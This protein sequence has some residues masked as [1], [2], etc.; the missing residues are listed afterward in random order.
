MPGRALCWCFALLQFFIKYIYTHECA[1]PLRLHT[2]KLLGENFVSVYCFQEIIREGDAGY[3]TYFARLGIVTAVRQVYHG[4]GF[5]LVLNDLMSAI[6]YYHMGSIHHLFDGDDGTILVVYLLGVVLLGLASAHEEGN[7]YEENC[8]F[9]ALFV[10]KFVEVHGT[11]ID[12]VECYLD[13][14]ST[15]Y[16]SADDS[17]SLD[18]KCSEIDE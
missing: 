13:A 14:I 10:F 17:E 6:P 11:R 12:D 18:D 8:L 3:A 15:S 5:L 2:G 4:L 9:H 1:I 16:Q 7:E